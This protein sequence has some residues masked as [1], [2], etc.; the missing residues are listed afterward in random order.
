MHTHA[1]NRYAVTPRLAL[2]S[3]VRGCGK[4]TLLGML[5]RLCR[6]GRRF[7]N[8]SPAFLYRIIEAEQPT[9]LLDEIDTYDLGSHGTFRRVLNGGHQRDS[10]T[11]RATPGPRGHN[12]F[13]TFAP[14]ALAA[15]GLEA[16]P[17]QLQDRSIVVKMRRADGEHHIRRLDDTSEVALI[18]LGQRIHAWAEKATLKSDPEMPATLRNRRADNQTAATT[19][20]FKADDPQDANAVDAHAMLKTAPKS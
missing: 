16:I 9:L 8:V 18:V 2:V 3:P 4:T 17:L 11:G 20:M 12:E 13:S 14:V 10:S 7:D 5:A 1:F 15:I 6:L 19:E